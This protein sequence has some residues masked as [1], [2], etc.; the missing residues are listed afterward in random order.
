M[1]A[2]FI[3]ELPS[4]PEPVG[5]VPSPVFTFSTEDP[6]GT[7]FRASGLK[8]PDG[9][10][11]GGR[12]K[13]CMVG[14]A[15]LEPSRTGDPW[16]LVP[17]TARPSPSLVKGNLEI[18]NFQL[19]I[20]MQVSMAYGCCDDVR[21]S[22]LGAE[23]R[24]G[25][26]QHRYLRRA[27]SPNWGAT[28][29]ATRSAQAQAAHPAAPASPQ[30]PQIAPRAATPQTPRPEAHD[31]LLI[32]QAAPVTWATVDPCVTPVLS[33][34]AASLPPVATERSAYGPRERHRRRLRLCSHFLQ[35][36]RGVRATKPCS[37]TTRRHGIP[38]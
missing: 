5:R 27:T 12:C 34:E 9:E 24:A 15:P 38:W 11:A 13:G 35:I 29:Q 7:A 6:S 23:G 1:R 30:A 28:D 2:P 16:V 3:G 19:C 33:T 31:P 14:S 17:D 36:R 37:E 21:V 25:P 10:A 26:A 32:S 22:G 8:A 20:H 4:A 18:A